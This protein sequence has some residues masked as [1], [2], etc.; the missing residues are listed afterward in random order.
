[1]VCAVSDTQQLEEEALD[2]KAI[3]ASLVGGCLP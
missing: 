3:A 1:V 2:E